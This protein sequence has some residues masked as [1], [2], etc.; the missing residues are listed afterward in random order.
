MRHHQHVVSAQNASV[1]GTFS[2]SGYGGANL[3]NGWAAGQTYYNSYAT[4][5]TVWTLLNSWGYSP[6]VA[7]ISNNWN[8]TTTSGGPVSG[9]VNVYPSVSGSTTGTATVGSSYTSN[10]TTGGGTETAPYHAYVRY[11]IRALQ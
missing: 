6:V 8:G 4:A 7:D 10:E 9:N 1:T 11:L 2:G 5:D 3:E